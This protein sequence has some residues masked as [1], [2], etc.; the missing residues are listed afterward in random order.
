KL[1]CSLPGINFNT[2]IYCAADESDATATYEYDGSTW[3]VKRI[4]GAPPPRLRGAM[5]FLPAIG[6]T[7]LFGGRAFGSIGQV[8]ADPRGA[9]FPENLAGSLL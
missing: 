5:A 1:G 8:V 4:A 9:P 6:K 7:V 2:N 3:N